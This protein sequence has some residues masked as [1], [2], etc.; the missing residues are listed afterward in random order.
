MRDLVIMKYQWWYHNVERESL[1]RYVASY[2]FQISMI[3]VNEIS[4][5]SYYCHLE[6]Q[7]LWYFAW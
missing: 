1:K 6:I 3:P 5:Q 7:Q 2:Y 4:V